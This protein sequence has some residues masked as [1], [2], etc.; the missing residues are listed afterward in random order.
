M[1]NGNR[2]FGRPLHDELQRV[3][4][5]A[6]WRLGRYRVQE[7]QDSAALRQAEHVIE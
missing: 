2:G 5:K 3:E 7:Q 4:R 6:C 1:R